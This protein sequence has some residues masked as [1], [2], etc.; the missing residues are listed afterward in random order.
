[1]GVVRFSVRRWRAEWT[2]VVSCVFTRFTRADRARFAREERRSQAVR[3]RRVQIE[4]DSPGSQVV[5]P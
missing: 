5:R 2:G 4:R 1:M 3:S